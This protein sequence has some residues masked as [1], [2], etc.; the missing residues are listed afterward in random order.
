MEE[1][2]NIP[3][4]N[5]SLES[6]DKIC[7]QTVEDKIVLIENDKITIKI[8]QAKKEKRGRNYPT[9]FHL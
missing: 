3:N 8:C 4:I 5:F 7:L 9:S 1:I 6:I 2:M